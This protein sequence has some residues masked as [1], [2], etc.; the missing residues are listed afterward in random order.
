[1]RTKRG[2]STGVYCAQLSLLCYSKA[3]PAV[4]LVCLNL[5]GALPGASVAAGRFAKGKLLL[6]LLQAPTPL[7]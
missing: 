3:T 7:S 4:L 2:F 5:N 1:M 6:V